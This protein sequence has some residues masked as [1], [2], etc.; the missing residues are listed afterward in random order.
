[1][2]TDDNSVEPTSKPLDPVSQ[3]RRDFLA[4]G[5]ILLVLAASALIA[6]PVVGFLFEPFM[7]N[8]PRV[9][10]RL[11]GTEDFKIGDTVQVTFE[12]S[13]P[14]P[15]DGPAAYSAA[16]LRR[17]SSQEFHAYSVDCTHLGCPVRWEKSAE[18]FL[19]PCHGGVYYKD[20]SVAAGPPP[21][22][23]IQYPVRIASGEVQIETSQI[24][25]V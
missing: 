25:L 20:G 18:L 13:N 3:F 1:M 23:L 7:R 5:S 6:T 21:H 14:Q 9:W 22:A 19:C 11:G 24:P 16:W 2:S 4:A 10:R 15:W 12:N 8:R 17:E